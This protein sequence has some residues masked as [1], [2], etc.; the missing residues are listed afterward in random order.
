MGWA[1][2]H[3]GA[4]IGH[5]VLQDHPCFSAAGKRALDDVVFRKWRRA[6]DGAKLQIIGCGVD[7]GDRQSEV[8]NLCRA[9]HRRK[10]FYA[11]K[12]ESETAQEKAPIVVAAPVFDEN[13][14]SLVRMGT[15][16]AKDFANSML[17][18]ETP[19]H[20]HLHIPSS[21][22]RALD[23]GPDGRYP[24]FD[25]LFAEK[26]VLVNKIEAWHRTNAMNTGEVWD[27][28]A[29]NVFM[30][31]LL[32][33][34]WPKQ[35]GLILHDLRPKERPAAYSGEDHSVMASV[36]AHEMLKTQMGD[37]SWSIVPPEGE[38]N[39]PD[40]LRASTPIADSR[41]TAPVQKPV[42]KPAPSQDTES[43]KPPQPPQGPIRR[44]AVGFRHS[45]I[46]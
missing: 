2:G 4:I 20:K 8:L 13:R 27:C 16:R 15:R 35:I 28:L 19:G 6:G 11:V 43:F 42:A 36:Y 1:E 26:K 17:Q 45:R 12:G 39:L 38:V 37:E 32:A 24:F 31:E 33:L 34:K 3:E 7:A 30:A 25:S 5:F 9:P 22:A 10:V 41:R 44:R 40:A 14:I 18:N 23:S 46:G 21:I 29:G